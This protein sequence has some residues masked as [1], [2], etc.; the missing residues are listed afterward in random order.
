V[1]GERG[2]RRTCLAE[3]SYTRGPIR[4]HFPCLRF[5]TRLFLLL[6]P[7]PREYSF[8]LAHRKAPPTIASTMESSN[9]SS[10]CLQAACT[11]TPHCTP[12][13]SLSLSLLSCFSPYYKVCF[14][15]QNLPCP[16]CIRS[17]RHLKMGRVLLTRTSSGYRA[18]KQ[19]AFADL[20][21][22][23]PRK[24]PMARL[25]FN[26]ITPFLIYTI[27]IVTLGPLLF[28]YHLVRLTTIFPLNMHSQTPGR[29]Q[30]TSE[31]HHM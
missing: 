10:A 21:P 28:G 24:S 31:G 30:C 9:N 2:P 20:V 27:C 22:T 7:M 19:A 5:A 8:R 26:G 1:R 17:R 6:H 3:P 23:P 11:V 13:R 25:Q 29:T 15:Y 14:P 16:I 4:L 18:I 12:V